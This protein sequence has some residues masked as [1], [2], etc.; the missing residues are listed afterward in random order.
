[1]SVLLWGCFVVFFFLLKRKNKRRKKHEYVTSED[2]KY[3]TLKVYSNA[4]AVLSN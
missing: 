1:M 2:G 4:S 3:F